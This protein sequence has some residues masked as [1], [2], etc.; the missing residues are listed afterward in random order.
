MLFRRHRRRPG[1]TTQ[2]M[3]LNTLPRSAAEAAAISSDVAQRAVEW[4][5]ELQAENVTPAIR[6]DWQR[7]RSAHPDHERAWQR[8]ESINGKLR[9]L[10]TPVSSAVT[11]ATL[12]APASSRRRQA[13]KALTI[14]FFAG[15]SVWML[16]Q[17]TP[18]RIWNAGQRTGPGQRRTLTLD[19]GS[20]LTLNTESAVD[21]HFSANERRVHLLAG[22]I[23]IATAKDPERRP[24]L[25]ESREGL[26]RAL[27]TRFTVA[28]HDDATAVAVFEGAVE[29]QP[30]QAGSAALILHAGQQTRFT[31]HAAAAPEMT[32]ESSAAWSTG[33]IIA[34]SMRLADFL[35]QLNRYSNSTLSCAAAIA[36]LR[37]SGSY[38]LDDINKIL[39]TLAAM[40]ELEVQT[41]P[42]FWGWQQSRTSLRPR[43]I[44]TA[45]HG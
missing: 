21:I 8:I 26:A 3:N 16:E 33:F 23:F 27:G 45:G 6:A 39:E 31:A 24:F 37:V 29:I 38:P 22:E 44:K 17:Q 43:S 18:W 30:R 2:H 34:R 42:R 15:G 12:T 20:S 7:W 28:Q 14:L 40:L 1:V 25:V 10:A 32:D 19:D 35:A 9:N 5:I 4:L 41:V 11:Q 36:D 13:V